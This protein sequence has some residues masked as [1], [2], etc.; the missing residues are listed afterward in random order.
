MRRG[1]SMTGNSVLSL[2]AVFRWLGGGVH[3]N[4]GHAL[5]LLAWGRRSTTGTMRILYFFAAFCW[6]GGVHAHSEDATCTGD[7]HACGLNEHVDAYRGLELA[8]DTHT[9]QAEG[10]MC[11]SCVCIHA[12]LHTYI[13]ACIHT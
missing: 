13:H 6:L 5:T 3:F 1:K 9:V 10:E 2:R 8:Y 4:L 12:C 7:Q 11:M